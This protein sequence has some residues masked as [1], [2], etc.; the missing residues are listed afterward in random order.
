M[1]AYL[2]EFFRYFLGDME[3]WSS[4]DERHLLPDP[5]GEDFSAFVPEEDPGQSERCD[6]LVSIDPLSFGVCGSLFFLPFDTG[7][8]IPWLPPVFL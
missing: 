8:Y 1:G 5:W 6:D 3:R 7:F 4:D 2:F